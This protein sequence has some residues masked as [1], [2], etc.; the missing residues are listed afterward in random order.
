MR[1]IIVRKKFKNYRY[2]ECMCDFDEEAEGLGGYWVGVLLCM[3]DGAPPNA[4]LLFTPRLLERYVC[5]RFF[6]IKLY[7]YVYN[8]S[9]TKIGEL[10]ASMQVQGLFNDDIYVTLRLDYLLHGGFISISE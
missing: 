7:S 8:D 5:F 6:F 1:R 3:W 4:D 10:G 9:P 2:L